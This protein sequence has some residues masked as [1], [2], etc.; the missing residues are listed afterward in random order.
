M[1]LLDT[2]L[3]WAAD[4]FKV[5]NPKI[6]GMISV[7]L[8]AVLGLLTEATNKGV[9]CSDWEKNVIA[10]HYAHIN[11]G[12]SLDLNVFIADS[13]VGTWANDEDGIIFADKGG[14]A[15]WVFQVA[16]TGQVITV[17][18]NSCFFNDTTGLLAKIMF[19]LTA[20]VMALTGVHTTEKKKQ[21]IAARNKK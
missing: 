2:L 7:G 12:D 16:D 4:F 17:A 5:R 18:T 3:I 14:I 13:I 1:V 20:I 9:V 11:P 8:L 15:T 10:D 21:I 19:W 6:F